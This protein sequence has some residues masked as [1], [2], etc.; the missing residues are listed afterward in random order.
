MKKRRSGRR[1]L[2]LAVERSLKG[3]VI[4][5]RLFDAVVEVATRRV[6]GG[7]R[8]QAFCSELDVSR[9]AL[10]RPRKAVSQNPDETVLQ[11][12]FEKPRVAPQ[13]GLE[14]ATS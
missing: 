12:T 6:E 9:V 2:G 10:K 4:R 11:E 5:S 1:C 7:Y 3:A 13:A 14:P 8:G